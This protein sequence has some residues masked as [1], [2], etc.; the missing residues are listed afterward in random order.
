M[1]ATAFSGLLA[2]GIL[3]GLENTLGLPG[4]RW[5]FII[6]GGASL[7]AGLASFF[8]LPD[9]VESETGS[10]KWLLNETERRVSIDRMKRDAI[11]NQDINHSLIHGLKL[12]AMDPK[13]W[14]FV[15]DLWLNFR[16]ILASPIEKSFMIAK[17]I[18]GFDAMCE[19]NC[20][21]FQLFLPN[22]C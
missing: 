12:A 11:S 10:T 16:A 8:L 2:A 9:F 20:L 15:S 3:A 21:W 18:I 4:W 22:N 17:S 14:L 13:T 6:E 1:L 19:S 5:L 7:V